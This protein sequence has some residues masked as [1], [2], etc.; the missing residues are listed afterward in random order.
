MYSVTLDRRGASPPSMT[1][2]P[3]RFTCHV[4]YPMTNQSTTYVYTPHLRQQNI[5]TY[6]QQSTSST[7]PPPPAYNDLFDVCTAL[8]HD[9]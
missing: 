3:G 6:I 1:V 8:P 9:V 7:L 5:H 4:T 2:S